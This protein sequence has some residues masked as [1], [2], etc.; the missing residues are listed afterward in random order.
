MSAFNGVT[1]QLG[2]VDQL[3]WD[4]VRFVFRF[5]VSVTQEFLTKRGMHLSAAIAF[6]TMLCLFPLSLL[7]VSVLVRIPGV[8]D[9]G[10]ERVIEALQQ[11]IPILTHET[12]QSL[13]TTLS[14]SLQRASG[15][16][17]LVAVVFLLFASSTVFSSIRT[18]INTIWG[19]GATRNFF[20]EKLMDIL[21][22][23]GAL[24]LLLVSVGLASI[25]PNLE[26]IYTLFNPGA[27][28]NPT[29]WQVLFS[30]SAPVL[31]FTVFAFL[32]W[33][34]PNI[35]FRFVAV[36]PP[37]LGAAVAFEISKAIFLFYL[38]QLGERLGDLYGTFAALVVLLVFVYVSSII[39]LA[40]ALVTARFM[41]YLNQYEQRRLNE[42]LSVNVSRVRATHSLPG[43]PVNLPAGA[44]R[45]TL[46]S[47]NATTRRDYRSRSDKS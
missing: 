35:R 33:W 26:G 47:S 28:F 40:G 27:S 22:I 45:D 10:A 14:E 17:S 44:S 23:F 9:T 41:R 31:S 38:G 3:L 6:Y 25:S 36:I 37:A 18:S 8:A 11:Q 15:A 42:R 12:A 7:M 20:I 46:N 16:G 13:V 19:I 2:R 24:V 32:Y 39:L 34:L 5:T 1:S 4:G 43:L 30:L 21:M 29:P